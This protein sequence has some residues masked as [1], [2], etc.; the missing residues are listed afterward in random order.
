MRP[1]R[2]ASGRPGTRLTPIKSTIF[3]TRST[4]CTPTGFLID[5]GTLADCCEHLGMVELAA[6]H[7]RLAGEG[8]P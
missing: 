6:E 2:P 7:R 5:V 1:A 4:P 3:S 8:S